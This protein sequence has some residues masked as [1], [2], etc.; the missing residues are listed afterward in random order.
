MQEG[1]RV[2]ATDVVM[3]F[4]TTA[5]DNIGVTAAEDAEAVVIAAI[6]Q[7][8]TRVGTLRVREVG[9]LYAV[10]MGALVNAGIPT[11]GW[12]FDRIAAIAGQIVPSTEQLRLDMVKE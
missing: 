9:H 3:T 4:S 6:E 12:T 10:A 8:L 1:E 11:E 2:A 5:R 7:D